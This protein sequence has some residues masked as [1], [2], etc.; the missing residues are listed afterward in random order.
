MTD[1]AYL[2][3]GQ[4]TAGPFLTERVE[5]KTA[6]IPDHAFTHTTRPQPTSRKALF[7]GRWRRVYA[8][9]DSSFFI[10]FHGKRIAVQFDHA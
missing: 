8:T 4:G 3:H 1:H 10:E 7:D 6:K 2:H 5:V 9:W